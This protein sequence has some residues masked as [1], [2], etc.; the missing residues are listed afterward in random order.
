M[1]HSLYRMG[2]WAIIILTAVSASF[3]EDLDREPRKGLD[4]FPL[5]AWDGGRPIPP[6][7]PSQEIFNDMYDCG[8]TVAG[9]YPIEKLDEIY[10]AGL[11]TFVT[12]KR[13]NNGHSFDNI[14][15]EKAENDIRELLD[16]VNNH[17]AV[18]GYY[19]VD[20]PQAGKF[21][22][23]AKLAE[24]YAEF[25]P[26]KE[27]YINLLP[28]YAPP[29]ML[30]TKDYQEYVERF[31]HEVPTRS[32]GYD[33]YGIMEDD[34]NLR[35][36]YWANLSTFRD[37]SLKYNK[38]FWTVVLSVGHFNYRVPSRADLSFEVFSSLLYGARGIAYFTYLAPYIG[39]YRLSPIDQFHHKTPLWEDM[40][41]V[42]HCV[43]ALAPTLNQL[44]STKV[45]HFPAEDA[46]NNHELTPP[47]DSTLLIDM[48]GGP[49][50]IGEF[51]HAANHFSYLMILN[52]N[53]KKSQPLQ[54]NWR[55]P[56]KAVRIV[57][58]WRKGETYNWGGEHT[59]L[60]PGEALLLEVEF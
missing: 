14:D 30:Q 21:P 59:W 9:F 8:L 19:I 56:P 31:I 45:Y 44:T 6:E 18:Y 54:L 34:D 52:K 36:G 17:P 47:D 38:P 42:N 5:I 3:A 23:L 22:E 46:A 60:A 26:D 55:N 53:L 10:N 4:F 28:N 48:P 32:F 15:Q 50:A 33:F 1:Y 41:Y 12:D 20:E 39:N 40:R 57:S 7:V 51:K 11:V 25:A 43:L 2:I 58:K 27:V 16:E 49:F 13:A 37:A 29:P 24:I 35:G